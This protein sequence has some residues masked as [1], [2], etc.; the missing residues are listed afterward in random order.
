METKPWSDDEV[1]AGIKAG[2]ISREK[3]L[4]HIF[5]QQGWKGLVVNYIRQN[6]GNEQDGEDMA[7]NALVIIDRNVRQGKFKGKSAL[8]TYFLSIARFQWYKELRSRRPTDEVKPEHYE[9]P[10]GNVEDSYINKEKKQYFAEALENIGLRCKMILML[11]QLEH[12]L[13]EIARMVELSSAAMAKK[14][15]YRCRMRFR[16]FLEENPGWKS[17]IV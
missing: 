10:S 9:E 14:E 1:A 6:G 3:A 8:K 17:L 5:F 13:E 12:T 7:Q 16:K 15:A 2:G 11:Q 4:Y